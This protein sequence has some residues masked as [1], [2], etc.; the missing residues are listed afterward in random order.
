MCCGLDLQCCCQP[1]RS[2]LLLPEKKSNTRL[3]YFKKILVSDLTIRIREYK[4]IQLMFRDLSLKP[5]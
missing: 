2:D 5:F 3:D 4:H 1:Y